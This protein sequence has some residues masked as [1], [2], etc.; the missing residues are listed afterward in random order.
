MMIAQVAGLDFAS[1]I[2][3][4]IVPALFA[5]TC[6]Y[7]LIWAISRRNL[8]GTV[9]GPVGDIPFPRPFNRSHTTKGLIILGL[10]IAFFFSSVPKEI[11]ALTAA[12][13]HFA[14]ARFRTDDL[15]GLVD[16]PILVLFMGLFVVNGVFLDSGYGDQAVQWFSHKGLNLQSAPVLVIFTAVLSNMIG[17]SAA[18]L[19]LA[20]VVNMAHPSTAYVL[21]LANSFGGSLII[22]GSVS[23]IIVVQQARDLGIKISFG[24][25]ARIGVPVTIVALAGLLGWISLMV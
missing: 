23:N 18:V 20:K 15:L 19:L 24:D 16:W 10:V 5:L 11:V 12:G 8:A 9:P 1:Y 13:V 17:N 4:C 21:A 2:L 25:F 7:G 22:V 3:W 6:A 14:S